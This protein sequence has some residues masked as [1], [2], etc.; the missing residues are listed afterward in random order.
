MLKYRNYKN[1]TIIC[2]I[3]VFLLVLSCH[4]LFAF[5]GIQESKILEQIEKGGKEEA[6]AEDLETIKR[7]YLEYNA[8]N[9]RD[10]FED[11]LARKEA[12]ELK[13]K[14][15]AEKD[16]TVT[17]LSLTIQGVVWGGPTPQAIINDRVVKKGDLIEEAEIIDIAKDGVTILYK[18]RIYRLSSPASNY[19]NAGRQEVIR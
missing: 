2:L 11:L 6:K 15:E 7:P 12:E 19:M 9:L 8:Y 16:T 1:I 5:F 10:P 14:A 4:C 3:L 18:K 13:K 17:P